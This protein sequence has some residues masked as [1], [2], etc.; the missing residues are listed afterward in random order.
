MRCC[1]T[2]CRNPAV[3]EVRFAASGGLA[4]WAYC[5]WH[6]HRNGRLRWEPWTVAEARQTQ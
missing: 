5:Q 4:W 3:V 2:S 6:G 1:V